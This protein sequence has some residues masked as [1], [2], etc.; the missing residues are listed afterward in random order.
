MHV[1]NTLPCCLII[2]HRNNLMNNCFQ[3][4]WLLFFLIALLPSCRMHEISINSSGVSIICSCYNIMHCFLSSLVP[5]GVQQETASAGLVMQYS[6]DLKIRTWFV[7]SIY[8]LSTF[9]ATHTH[10][11]AS[12]QTAEIHLGQ[13]V[14]LKKITR[15]VNFSNSHTTK[16]QLV[17]QVPVPKLMYKMLGIILWIYMIFSRL[18]T[19]CTLKPDCS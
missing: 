6:V 4:E 8:F 2:F 11:Y 9:S 15:R 12:S 10:A 1:A 14:F 18:K 5:T 3:L 17:V 7:F 13:W 16:F 19:N